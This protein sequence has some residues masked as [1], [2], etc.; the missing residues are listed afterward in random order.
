MT[1]PMREST[2]AISSARFISSWPTI[3]ENGKDTLT[4]NV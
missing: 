4:P 2:A 1:P 3:A